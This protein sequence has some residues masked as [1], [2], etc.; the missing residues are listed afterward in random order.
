MLTKRSQD[1]YLAQPACVINHAALLSWPS[2]LPSI[3]PSRLRTY[4]PV[5]FSANGAGQEIR[6]IRGQEDRPKPQSLSAVK[7]PVCPAEDAAQ[8]D[9]S[10]SEIGIWSV[11]R[12]CLFNISTLNFSNAESQAVLALKIKTE[13][14]NQFREREGRCLLRSCNRAIDRYL[15]A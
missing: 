4:F 1:V 10:A 8:G 3:F 9:S 2:I 15:C 11:A 12:L 6:R 14:N 13:Q 5:R 7:A